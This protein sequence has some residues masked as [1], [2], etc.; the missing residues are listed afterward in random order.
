MLR[1]REVLPP[2]GPPHLY[3]VITLPSKTN[4]TANIGVVFCF[5]D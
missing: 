4:T 2:T 1:K 5:I 3:C